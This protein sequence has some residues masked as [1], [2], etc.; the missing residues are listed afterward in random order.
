MS[1]RY[2]DCSAAL[3]AL[4]NGLDEATCHDFRAIREVVMCDAWHGQGG[5]VTPGTFRQRVDDG[6][7]KVRQACAAHG[8]TTPEVGFLEPETATPMEVYQ[9]TRNGAQ[10]GLI[11]LEG[12]EVSV[13]LEDKCSVTGGGV[14]S[15]DA[16]RSVLEIQGYEVSA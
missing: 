5:E 9:V 11:T 12:N 3:Q 14:S 8:G 2:P 16:L 6:W 1:R 4:A 7:S 10:V 15:L 13:C